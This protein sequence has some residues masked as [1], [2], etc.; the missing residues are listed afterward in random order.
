MYVQAHKAISKDSVNIFLQFLL[1]KRHLKIHCD[2]CLCLGEN[3]DNTYKLYHMYLWGNT[4]ALLTALF[5]LISRI[6]N[7]K[8]GW[9]I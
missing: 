1:Y 8:A 3:P 7:Y 5:P 6:M 4:F 9:T 2:R